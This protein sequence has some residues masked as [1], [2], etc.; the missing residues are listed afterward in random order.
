ME[1]YT[2]LE[3]VS[4]DEM[5]PDELLGLVRRIRDYI[6]STTD[7]ER[8]DRLWPADPA[9]FSTGPTSLSYGASGIALLLAQEGLPE[10]CLEWIQARTRATARDGVLAP[11]LSTGAAGI[12]YSLAASGAHQAAEDLLVSTAAAPL[13]QRNPTLFNGLAGWAWACLAVH[14]RAGSAALLDLARCAGDDLLSRAV[15]N[16][17]G[18]FWAVPGV[19]DQPL[20]LGLG[21]SGVSLFLSALAHATGD[22]K[23]ADASA[24]ALAFDLSYGRRLQGG[25]CWG[26]NIETTGT[27]PY[28]S[29]GSA[30]VGVALLRHA[31]LT[32]DR[33]MLSAS[34]DA[35]VGVGGLF[36]G[37]P[38]HN[39][40][41]SGLGQFLLDVYLE[42]RDARFLDQAQTYSQ[43][44][45]CFMMEREAG[46]AFP[47]KMYARISTDYAT[48]SAGVGLFLA[49]LAEPTIR[50]WYDLP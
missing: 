3:Q 46:V 9:V 43:S 38:G 33:E 20:G 21:A 32:G 1:L 17:K 42:T 24:S 29:H 6:I 48:G 30:G 14:H 23:Y 45:L 41:M 25:L 13:L 19:T 12:A 10:G 4:R 8:T 15:T 49:R 26:A 2:H 37:Y 28:V 11:G 35:A 40:G 44:I 18:S 39:E 50:D 5:P 34:M 27:S 22:S 47:G 16:E 7:F 36:A 31:Q